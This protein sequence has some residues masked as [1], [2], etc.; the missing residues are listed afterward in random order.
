[1]NFEKCSDERQDKII[2]VTENNIKFIIQN[3]SENTIKIVTVDQQFPITT[4]F[5]RLHLSYLASPNIRQ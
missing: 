4:K 1:M 5:C 2:T 3:N